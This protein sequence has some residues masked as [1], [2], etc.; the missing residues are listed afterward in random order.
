MGVGFPG[1]RSVV[2]LPRGRMGD[3]DGIEGRVEK[4]TNEDGERDMRNGRRF[5]PSRGTGRSQRSNPFRWGDKKDR[6]KGKPWIA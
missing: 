1:S 5:V 6:R 4:R 3:D 2:T